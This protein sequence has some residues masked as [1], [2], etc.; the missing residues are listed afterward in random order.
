MPA[1]AL[2]FIFANI[3]VAVANK[4]ILLGLDLEKPIPT[5]RRTLTKI[6]FYFGAWL[7]AISTF[8]FP[9]RKTVNQDYSYWLGPDYKKITKRPANYRAPTYVSN[10]GSG[11]DVFLMIVALFADV[12]FLAKIEVK[13][14]PFVGTGVSAAEGLFCPRGGS[15]EAK[16]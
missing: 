14:I 13:S 8:C 15:P 6:V 1:K 10:H 5:H 3:I 9:V 4:V 7:M 11:T 16:E 12:S 2:G